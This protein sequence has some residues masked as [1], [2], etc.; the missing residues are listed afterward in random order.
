MR[1]KAKLFPYPVLA[2]SFNNDYIDSEF[3]ILLNQKITRNSIII[4]MLPQL[5][6]NGLE[7]LIK[8]GKASFFMHIECPYTCFR[9]AYAIPFEGKMIEISA[10]KV[11]GD[12]QLC[13]FIVALGDLP[14]YTNDCFNK[15]YEN[16]SFYLERGNI[17][18]IGKE[19]TITIE[20][21]NDNLSNVPSIFAVTEIK[22]ENYE[23]IVID[24]TGDKICLRLPSKVFRNFVSM[25]QNNPNAQPVLH[26]MLIIPALIKCIEELKQKTDSLYE[27][28]ER[29][30]FKVLNKAAKNVGYELN[31]ESLPNIDSFVLSQKIMENTVGRGIINLHKIAIEGEE[32][33]D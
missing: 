14:D 26:S 17:L 21:E 12:I 19:K 32:Y 2:N 5:M 10:D 7:Q 9:E 25:N 30:W 15:D 33:E 11:E 29:R 28:E 6:N 16:T 4:K 18:A 1:I 24:Y 23:D 3:D 31:P 20:K 27:Y 13:P 22:D 8:D